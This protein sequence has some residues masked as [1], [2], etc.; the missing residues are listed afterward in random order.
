VHTAVAFFPGVLILLLVQ[1][2]DPLSRIWLW[3]IPFAAMWA[4]AGLGLLLELIPS[5]RVGKGLRLLF[6]VSVVAGL[7][8][9]G[10]QVSSQRLI[11]DRFEIQAEEE[12]ARFLAPRLTPNTVVA[13]HY[14]WDATFWYYFYLEG[15]ER[16]P[17]YS[18]QRDTPFDEVYVPTINTSCDGG[19]VV[20]TLEAVGPDLARLNMDEMREVARIDSVTVCWIPSID[21]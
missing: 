10:L 17:I 19:D 3:V 6:L 9:M 15:I 14:G 16:S 21:R 11:N 2:P 7:A 13:L 18:R 4:S 1:R 5:N 8:A 12:V 20:H